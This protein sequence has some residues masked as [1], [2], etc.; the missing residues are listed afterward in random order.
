MSGSPT[1]LTPPF[2]VLDV[3]DTRRYEEV[4]A[5]VWKPIAGSGVENECARCG[6]LHEVHAHVR[7]ANGT[8]AVVGTGCMNADRAEV[9]KLQNKATSTARK[10]AKE[11]AATAA[12]DQLAAA[13]AALPV[14][15][16]DRVVRDF[17]DDGSPRWS[18]D[19]VTVSSFRG[20]THDDKVLDDE[21]LRSLESL[22]RLKLVRD[23]VGG[24][25]AYYA[26]CRRAGEYADV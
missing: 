11:A 1:T 7:D 3:V 4:D 20:E 24:A 9:R 6:K 22:W 26:L 19:G 10:A 14:F 23:A 13:V 8:E 2:T 12:R 16:A 18:L 5:D 25:D 15:P 17:A 21:R